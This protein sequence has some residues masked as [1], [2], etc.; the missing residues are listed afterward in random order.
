VSFGLREQASATYGV[1]HT[2][3]T[4]GSAERY[5]HES[6]TIRKC[7]TSFFLLSVYSKRY[8]RIKTNYL[9]HIKTKY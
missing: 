1:F 2:P 7:V 3:K 6:K 8:L 5:T 9:T 4:N